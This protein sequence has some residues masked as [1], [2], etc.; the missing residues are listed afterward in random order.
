MKILLSKILRLLATVLV[1]SALTFFMMNLLPGNIAYWVAGEDASSE[2]VQA[3]RNELGLDENVFIRYLRWMGKVVGGD[4][5]K[6]PRTHE[7]VLAAIAWRLPVTLELAM[8]AQ[9]LALLPAIPLGIACGFRPGSLLDR[10]VASLAFVMMS[11]PGFVTALLLIFILAVHFKVLPAT[12]YIPLAESA[13]GNLK[14]FVLPGLAIATSEWVSLMRVLRNDMMATLQ[15]SYILTA[16][17][18]GLPVPTILWRHAL[19]PS[20]LTLV[21][22]FGLQVGHLIGGLVIVESIF[23]LPGIGRLLITAVYARDILMVQGCILVITVGYVGVNFLV[24]MVY[25]L[26]DPRIE[27][28]RAPRTDKGEPVRA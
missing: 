7:P 11:L 16:R 4:L 26:L 19:R 6:S 13:W 14:S 25:S 27:T 2:D 17:S 12:G 5:G 9:I 3:I 15:E 10:T 22:V 8:I 28:V 23:A 21:T 24:D 18:K 1:V 20:S